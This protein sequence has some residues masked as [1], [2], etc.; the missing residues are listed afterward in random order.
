MAS[1][2]LLEQQTA[3]REE[4]ARKLKQISEPDFITTHVYGSLGRR[5][6]RGAVA[7]TRLTLVQNDGTGAATL[8]YDLDDGKRVF[9]KVY[10][11]ESGA[12]SHRVL[13][14]L[15]QDGFGASSRYRVSEPLAFLPDPN[16]LLIRGAD[17]PTV[18]MHEDDDALADGSREAARWLIRM[19]STSARI[20][21]TRYPLE[22]YHKLMHRLSKAAAAHPGLVNDL[23]DHCDRFDARASRL[24]VRFVQ[25]HGQFRHIHVFLGGGAVTV[26]D[27]D[28]SRPADPAKDLAEFIHRMRTKR[29]KATG[30]R[31]RAEEPTRA[32]L[33]EYA[34]QLPQN[35]ANLSFYWG[36]HCL[37]SLWKYMKSA[38][39]G[40]PQWQTLV[41]FYRSEFELAASR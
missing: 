38:R 22:V 35:L 1:A 23:I 27:L 14:A 16:V 33:E 36:Y 10:V 25:S 3:A 9:A 34:S 30:G 21:D 29:F 11:D 17:G 31:S 15:W 20:G 7:Q 26:I 37:V 41:E 32:F 40:Q 8:Q 19:H 2:R 39:P 4:L 28:R 13:Q 5:A 18:A 12:H 6:G 24:H